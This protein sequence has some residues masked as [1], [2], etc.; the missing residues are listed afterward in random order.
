M[1]KSE[2]V[3]KSGESDVLAEKLV[4]GEVRVS[5]DDDRLLYTGRIEW[6]NPKAP[7]F[8]Y[9]G[10]SVRFRFKG[11][12][13][14]LLILNEHCCYHNYLGICIDQQIQGKVE[15][16]EHGKDTIIT[17][18]H[19][20]EDKEHEIW[21]YKCQDS[22]HYVNLKMIILNDGAYL[23]NPPERPSRRIECFGDSISCGEI[24]E[25]VDY[26]GKSDPP[27]EGEYSNGWY[28]Y[29]FMTARNLNAELHDTS[30]GGISLFDQT[31]WFHGP[32]YIGLES[33]YDKIRYNTY[34][35]PMTPWDFKRYIPHVVIIAIGQ[36]DAHP[37][38]YMGI[39]EAKSKH[40]KDE[41]EGFIRKLQAV[42][43]KALFIL[44]TTILEHSFTWDNAIDE[45]AKR[46]NDPKVVHFLYSNNSCGT[47][48]HVRIPEAAQM[49]K[50]LT[51]FIN[52]FGDGIW[53]E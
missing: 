8:V 33:T 35:G 12:T 28:S 1:M 40:W 17:M 24:S 34:L 49:A 10:S 43:P 9:V 7:C 11:T 45:V 15:I 22:S 53:E 4:N 5:P 6:S 42:Y 13:V 23:L 29:A 21:I 32:D 19:D 46:M 51:A 47:P 31:G 30:Q 2:Q 39:D 18:A 25:A 50:E 14:K 48:G 36:N 38:D 52:S 26:V 41:Y 20:L 37:E 16:L 3:V 27:Q 44:T